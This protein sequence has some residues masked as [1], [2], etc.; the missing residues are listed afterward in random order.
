MTMTDRTGSFTKQWLVMA[1]TAASIWRQGHEMTGKEWQFATVVLHDSEQLE[2]QPLCKLMSLTPGARSYTCAPTRCSISRPAVQNNPCLISAAAC[3]TSGRLRVE[4]PRERIPHGRL[5]IADRRHRVR[6]K[7]R[8]KV[9]CQD[10]IQPFAR[11]LPAQMHLQ[12]EQLSR[13]GQ[14]PDYSV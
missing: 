8:V 1:C 4:Q 3:S 7:D 9:L 10:G 5:A 6:W 13:R 12:D 14:Q 2:A 11:L